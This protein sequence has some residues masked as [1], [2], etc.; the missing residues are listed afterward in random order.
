M[1]VYALDKDFNILDICDDYKSIIWTTRYFTPGDFELYLPATENNINLLLSA[2]YLVRDKDI[3]DGTFK[4][5]MRPKKFN[6]VTSIDDGNYLTVTGPCIKSILGQRIVWQQTT[7]SG[8]VETGIRKVVDENAINPSISA[9]KISKLVL[10]AIKGF[11]ETMKKQATGTNLSEFVADV[12]TAYGIGWD[13]FIKDKKF[14]FELYKGKDRSYAQGVNPHVVFSQ[15]FD[16]FLSSDYT[17]DKTKYKN[18]ALVAGEG[19]GLDRKRVSVGN[20]SDLD[21]YEIYIDSRDSSTNDGEI[22]EEEYNNMLAEEGAETLSSDDC[23]VAEH[24]DAEIETLSNY[25][26]GVDYFLGDIVE[27]INEY[28]IETTPRIIEVIESEDENGTST[29]PTFSS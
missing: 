20:A 17:L 9:R 16:N 10:G 28:G 2:A 19:E 13:V 23:T 11:S 25:E 29:I 14:V 24:I 21:R 5:V 22:T 4:N 1:D 12:C 18:V 6:I 15:E 26:F 7:L 3:S 27:V 8:K